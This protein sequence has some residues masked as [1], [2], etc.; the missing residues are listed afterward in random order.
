MADHG[1]EGVSG[2][3]RTPPDGG[4]RRGPAFPVRQLVA[5]VSQFISLQ[6]GDVISPVV[7]SN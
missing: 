5:Y 4:T 6:V 1:A 7:P 3:G 2:A